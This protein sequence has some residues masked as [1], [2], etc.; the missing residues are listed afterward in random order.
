MLQRFRD[1]TATHPIFT[2]PPQVLEYCWSARDPAEYAELRT[3]VELYT[4]AA[5]APP[6]SAVLDVQQALWNA[7]LARGAGNADVLIAAYAIANDL[8]VLHSDHDFEHIQRALAPAV[9][10]KQEFVAE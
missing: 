10:L 7:G 6:T 1:I 4:P 8:T 9:S 5:V 3:D 2:C